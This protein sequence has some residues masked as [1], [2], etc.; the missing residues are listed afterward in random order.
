MYSNCLFEAI[1]AKI[2][3][4]KNVHIHILSPKLNNG[5]FH[6]Y[7][8]DNKDKHIY[9]YTYLNSESSGLL[10]AGRI[11]DHNVKMFESKLYSKMNSLNWT[12][13]QQKQY[14]IKKGFINKEPFSIMIQK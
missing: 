8:Y 1:K 14:A 13:E 10:F 9:H 11:T 12:V 7:W 2:K 3:D 4:P 6:I 5:D